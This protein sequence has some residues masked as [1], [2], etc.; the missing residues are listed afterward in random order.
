MAERTIAARSVLSSDPDAIHP[1]TREIVLSGLR[2]TAIDAFAA[3]YKL[4]A[5]RRVADHAFQQ[6]RRVSAADRSHH[7]FHQTGLSRPNTAQQSTRYLHKFRQSA[8]S[9]DWRFPSVTEAGVPFG[10]TL[11]A[12]GGAD[13]RLAEIGRVFHADNGL[14][15]GALKCPGTVGSGIQYRWPTTRSR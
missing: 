6:G 2:P 12:P 4:E 10:I 8:R 14:P 13:A 11:L 7:L 15:L 5:L 1:V 9:V 3:F